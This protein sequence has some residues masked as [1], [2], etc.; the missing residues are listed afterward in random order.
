[1]NGP[2]WPQIAMAAQAQLHHVMGHDPMGGP[3]CRGTL[4][5]VF[6]AFNDTAQICRWRELRP[7]AM[8]DQDVR[9]YPPPVVSRLAQVAVDRMEGAL[10]RLDRA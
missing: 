5:A 9:G 10:V 1:M 3:G 6:N 2:A 7:S 8:T 4:V